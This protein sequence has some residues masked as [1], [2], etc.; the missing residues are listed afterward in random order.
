MGQGEFVNGPLAPGLNFRRE[1][2]THGL[3]EPI[4]IV[5]LG[6]YEADLAAT[7][8]QWIIDET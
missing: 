4:A 2:A 1:T 6:T 3:V 7:R 8:D 5:P